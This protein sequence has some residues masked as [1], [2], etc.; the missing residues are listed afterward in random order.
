MSCRVLFLMIDGL[1]EVGCPQYEGQT[2][3]QA[4]QLPTLDALATCGLT[5]LMDPVE[6]GLACGSDT[7]HMAIFGY[8]PLR[9]YMGRGSFESL[10][11]GIE[12]TYDDIAFKCNF[13]T[14]D[15]ET[16]IVTRRRVDRDFPEWGLP[17][18]DALNGKVIPGYENC[19][20]TVLHA[21]EHRCGVRVRGKGLSA[22]ITD[23]D[24]L[25]DHLPLLRVQPTAN[26]P[27]A[28]Y[29]AEVVNALSDWIHSVL[30]VHPINLQRRAKN[31]PEANIVLLRGC[32]AKLSKS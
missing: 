3:M 31:L 17:L 24:P 21:T 29:T 19:L 9:N 8:D 18:C 13:S 25:R 20:V 12:M 10:G 11:A 30:S 5:G 23:T 28:I 2:Y 16:G 14:M 26:T 4:A 6:T 7:A 1:G 32:G 15:P 27:E 22:Q